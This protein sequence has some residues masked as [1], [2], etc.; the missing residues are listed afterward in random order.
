MLAPR[1]LSFV[2]PCLVC[3]PAHQVHVLGLPSIA[4][5]AL[6]RSWAS[7]LCTMG[8]VACTRA[9]AGF[10]FICTTAAELF[11]NNVCDSHGTVWMLEGCVMSGCPDPAPRSCGVPCSLQSAGAPGWR[12]TAVLCMLSLCGTVHALPRAAQGWPGCGEMECYAA[13]AKLVGPCTCCCGQLGCG[14]CLA[15][16]RGGELLLGYFLFLLHAQLLC[17]YTG[18]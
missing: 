1:A 8:G 14:F 5:P 2:W 4:G 9:V 7:I 11:T 10:L 12:R 3:P 15:L 18:V 13:R 6:L 17:A 16:S